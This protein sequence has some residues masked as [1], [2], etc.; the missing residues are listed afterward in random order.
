MVRFIC[1]SSVSSVSL[2]IDVDSFD[3]T[4]LGANTVILTVTDGSGNSSTADAVVTVVDNIDPTITAPAAVTVNVDAASC[5][6]TG[7]GLGTPTTADNCSVASTTSDAPSVFP[8]GDTVVTWT[9]TDGSGNTATATQTVTVVD[10][11]DPTIT[12]P[13]AVTLETNTDCTATGYDLGSPITTDNCSV[14]T[15]SNDAPVA[16]PLGVTTV[17]W[18]VTDGSGNST[19][20]TQIVTVVDTVNP[21]AVAQDL[22]VSLD[23]FGEAFITVDII[24]NGSTDNC[25]IDSL[26]ISE[27]VF[28]CDNIGFN[29]VTLTVT[30]NSGNV[31]TTT[32]IVTVVNTFGDND[33]D[34]ILDNCDDDDDNDGVFDVD[35]NCPYTPNPDQADND[36]D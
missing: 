5:E 1:S 7:V 34:G 24:D 28:N 35:D 8:L 25:G 32:A 22:I 11:I 4:N 6:A 17:T 12:A 14:A 10:N 20:A 33:G 21:L 9:V 26:E 30:D 31:A 23:E 13:A 27:T 15:V 2:S 29:S 18:T 16:F 19:N 3:C 36:M